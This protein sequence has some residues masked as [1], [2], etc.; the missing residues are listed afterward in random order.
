M[1]KK[2]SYNFK[3]KPD[4]HTSEIMNIH[5]ECLSWKGPHGTCKHVA[6]VLIVL[7][8]NVN[9]GAW[10]VSKSCTENFQAFHKP[11]QPYMGS[12]VKAKHLPGERKYSLRDLRRLKYRK[13][14]AC[15]NNVRYLISYCLHT[16]KDVTLRY[17]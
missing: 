13:L 5:C 12:P 7:E 1:E 10:L 8:K 4:F 14:S 9:G 16:S 15:E 6:A 11:K 17:Q 2:G 3:P